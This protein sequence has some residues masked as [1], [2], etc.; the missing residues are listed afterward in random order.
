MAALLAWYGANGRRLVIRQTRDPYAIWVAET[1]SQQTQ[2]G[3]VG[4]ALPAFLARFPDVRTLAE[5]PTGEVLRAWGGLGYP[6]R[7]LALRD[8]AR[9]MVELHEGQVPR[10]VEALEALP[11]IGPYTARAV[12]ATAFGTPV[13]AL[14]VNARRVV[15]RLL[16]GAAWPPAPT[17]SAQARADALAPRQAAADW[18]HALMDLGAAVCRATPDCPGCPVRRWCAIGSGRVAPRPAPVRR[19]ASRPATPFHTTNRYVRG[20]VLAVLRDASPGTWTELDATA[21][22]LE[23]QRLGRAIV[24]LLAEGLVERGDDAT[25]QALLR[26]P[27]A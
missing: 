23:P 6:R 11:G 8:A 27:M 24:E 17:P 22:G 18:N 16:D 25:G 7:A 3:R 21:L 1:M 19:A 10:D 13:T 26:L 2:I 5:A 9:A 12:A 15:G 20:R 4:E 14:D